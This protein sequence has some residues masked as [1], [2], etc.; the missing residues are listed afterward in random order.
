M[1]LRL[2][3]VSVATLRLFLLPAFFFLPRPHRVRHRPDYLAAG[4]VAAV[5]AQLG[6]HVLAA[7][8]IE[9]EFDLRLRP[10]DAD[11]VDWGAVGHDPEAPVHAARHVDAKARDSR[12]YGVA[13]HLLV[14]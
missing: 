4:W 3:L 1:N 6:A 10:V 13:H 7:T 12:R 14:N 2:V 9:R 8:H 5:A 11:Y